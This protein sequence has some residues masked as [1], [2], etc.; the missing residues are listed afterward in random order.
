VIFC[1]A[2]TIVSIIEITD[3]CLQSTQPGQSSNTEIVKKKVSVVDQAHMKFIKL[4]SRSPRLPYHRC[5]SDSSNVQN[6]QTA[7]SLAPSEWLD[8]QLAL[9]DVEVAFSSAAVFSHEAQF[10]AKMKELKA[11]EAGE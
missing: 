4:D 11:R 3:V 9:G 10:V 2:K 1:S 8:S 7:T 6:R 5:W